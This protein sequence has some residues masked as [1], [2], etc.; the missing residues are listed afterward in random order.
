MK[1][2]EFEARQRCLDFA[3]HVG[4]LALAAMVRL[5][6]TWRT[7]RFGKATRRERRPAPRAW[8]L[9]LGLVEFAGPWCAIVGPRKGVLQ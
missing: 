2:A 4:R 9:P 1:G 3:A 8:N 6:K 7:L 5:E